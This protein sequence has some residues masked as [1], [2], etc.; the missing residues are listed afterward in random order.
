[1]QIYCITYLVDGNTETKVVYAKKTGLANIVDALID[2]G[3]R[4]TSVSKGEH[5][6]FSGTILSGDYALV[7]LFFKNRDEQ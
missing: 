3:Y 1:M 7:N 5:E 2:S 6:N 4:I